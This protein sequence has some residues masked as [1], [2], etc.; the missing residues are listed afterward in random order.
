MFKNNKRLSQAT[1]LATTASDD[2]LTE[3]FS[4]CSRLNKLSVGFRT[5]GTFT[6]W[7]K[8]VE[9]TEGDFTNS[10]L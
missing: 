2:A 9:T 4:G 10:E 5:W 6:D 3:M 8:G 1:I 7:V